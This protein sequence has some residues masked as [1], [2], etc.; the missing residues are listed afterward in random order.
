MSKAY[1][2]TV[3]DG[4]GLLQAVP[5]SLREAKSV[6][7]TRVRVPLANVKPRV[8]SPRESALKRAALVP[9]LVFAGLMV[10]QVCVSE[11]PELR[12]ISK[13]CC[14]TATTDSWPPM[15][16]TTPLHHNLR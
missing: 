14:G 7:P 6:D 2:A 5:S 15:T 11:P 4:Q 8:T 9:I 12:V 13:I 10:F 16:V 1:D 3:A